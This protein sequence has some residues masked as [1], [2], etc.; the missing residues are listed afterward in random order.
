M[1]QLFTQLA[2]TI[3]LLLGTDT[4]SSSPQN[5]QTMNTNLTTETAEVITITRVQAPESASRHLFVKGFEAAIPDYQ[6]IPALLSKS[7]ALSSSGSY[8]G[9]I[10]YWGS[11]QAA[12]QWF[13]PAWFETVKK[14]YKTE[15]EVTYYTVTGEQIIQTAATGS[16]KYWSVVSMGSNA[17]NTN[18]K[19]LLNI[20]FVKDAKGSEGHISLWQ[21][22]ED[23][24]LY[25]K[26]NLSANEFFDTPVLMNN[27]K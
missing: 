16:G 2:A 13:G 21:T 19:G 7:F 15:G 12:E 11:R 6:K 24:R 14:K 4:T 27:R 8:F 25:Y 22:E 26:N 5:N 3:V 10:Y 20:A 17:I 23:A 9:G 1:T 18:A